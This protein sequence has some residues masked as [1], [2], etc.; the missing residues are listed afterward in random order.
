MLKERLYRAAESL[1]FFL[2][3]IFLVVIIV[4]PATVTATLGTSSL[5]KIIVPRRRV[6]GFVILLGLFVVILVVIFVVLILG[7]I[8]VIVRVGIIIAGILMDGGIIHL[9]I[10]GGFLLGRSFLRCLT[11]SLAPIDA[12]AQRQ[13]FLLGIF[14]SSGWLAGV[15]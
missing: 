12:I 8:M 1:G 2:F 11:G 6:V 13:F 7:V 3:I 9:I 5:V 4:V 15:G 14:R 10:M